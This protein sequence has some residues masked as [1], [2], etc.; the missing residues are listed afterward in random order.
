MTFNNHSKTPAGTS[1]LVQG[2]GA[3]VVL[4]HG[5]GLD[6]SMWGGQLVGLSPDY[7]IIAYDMLGHGDSAAPTDDACLKDYATQLKELLD[8]LQLD[9]V[10][11]LGFSMGGLVA[12]AFALHYPQYLNGLVI[13]NSVF[14]RSEAQRSGVMARTLEVAKKGPAAN[15]ETALK[16]WFSEEYAASS[17]AQI[18]AVRDTVLGNDHHGY[19][20][21]YQLFAS[22]DNYMADRLADIQVPTLVM[23]GEL[24]PGSTPEM[25]RAM[26]ARIPGAEAVVIE[27]ERHMM[28]MESPKRVNEPLLTFLA[29]VYGQPAT[30]EP[31]TEEAP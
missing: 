31:S 7:Q 23:T 22:E 27:D 19:L 30:S 8:H 9:K 21:T 3:P 6:K 1:Y 18:N 17:P 12:R 29:S 11:V 5:V 10:L 14:N 4:I 2:N 25:A 24:D 15:V 13:L 16:R 20:K 26:A 28:P